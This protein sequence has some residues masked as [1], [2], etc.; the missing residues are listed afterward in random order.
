MNNF[1]D[2]FHKKVSS[3]DNSEIILFTKK[4]SKS[5]FKKETLTQIESPED[6][7]YDEIPEENEAIESS[8]IRIEFGFNNKIELVPKQLSDKFSQNTFQKIIPKTIEDEELIICTPTESI[9]KNTQETIIVPSVHLN[10]QDDVITIQQPA[11]EDE[12]ELV[13]IENE[14]E[15]SS[16]DDGN[17][18]EI[19]LK[20]G[21]F[22]NFNLSRL[23]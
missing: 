13:L 11:N 7:C 14:D 1:E 17:L 8:A 21:N 19:K 23:C 16:S 12:N 15:D 22:L 3:E 6:I 4:S 9:I 2:V 5:M 10:K 18:I 20:K